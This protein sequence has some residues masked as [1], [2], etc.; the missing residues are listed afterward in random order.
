MSGR[1]LK[2]LAMQGA[3][4]IE[5]G[6]TRLAVLLTDGVAASSARVRL[7]DTFSAFTLRTPPSGAEWAVAIASALLGL[8]TPL[9]VYL[10]FD[11]GI[12][13]ADAAAG[14]RFVAGCIVVA[15]VAACAEA[16]LRILRAATADRIAR[17]RQ[18]ILSARDVARM[19]AES[20]SSARDGSAPG[21][22]ARLE[23]VAQFDDLEAGALRRAVLDTPAIL[24]SLVAVAWIGG[25]V[26]LAPLTLVL[27]MI[28]LFAGGGGGAPQLVRVRDAHDARSDD[29][30]AECAVHLH[31]IKAGALEP[32]MAR[33]MESLLVSGRQLERRLAGSGLQ[34]DDM[35]TLVEAASVL[36]VG[37]LGGL[38]ALRGE[39]E[40][41]ALAACALL[42]VG[43]VRP[44]TRMASAAQRSRLLQPEAVQDE[45]Q[46]SRIALRAAN[47]PGVLQVDATMSPGE[48]P[49]Q[50]T[51]P[52]GSV[53]AVTA[54]DGDRMSAVMRVLAG[55]AAPDSGAVL[56]GG[57]AVHDYRLAH[58]GA[59]ALVSHRA[60]LFSGTIL[61]NLTWFGHGATEADA[62]AACDVLGLRREIDRLPRKLETQVGRG[63]A[64]CIS[65]SL[66]HRLCIARA[67]ALS[68]R[69][70]LLDE[71]Q[72][73]LDAQADRALIAGLAALKG[74][75]TVIMS[76]SR[77]SY[78]ALADMVFVLDEGRFAPV[79]PLK[80]GGVA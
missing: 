76:T 71:P 7:A 13:S 28:V 58:G 80:A 66:T 26:A 54:R 74:R 20:P 35:R 59:I 38:A 24:V 64:D 47:A 42:A 40:V 39:I 14:A 69:V 44:A 60:T 5:H 11:K 72:A 6:L 4:A 3:S 63:A 75:M 10:A 1:S 67:I 73:R 51:A 17:H 31:A 79:G 61:E 34:A 27:A 55:L 8:A 2:D 15:M 22:V 48:T 23:A 53:V 29:F 19:V 77:P 18:A 36:A 46:A 37:A 52:F 41:G 32:F 78:Q 68:P 9:A 57:A 62:L 33:R 43:I 70:L 45:M 12:L 56:L 25:W 65:D 21:R 50:F 30:V 16:G 49:V